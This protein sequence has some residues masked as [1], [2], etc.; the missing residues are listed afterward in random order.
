[1]NKEQKLPKETNK[2]QTARVAA[3]NR[4]TQDAIRKKQKGNEKRWWGGSHSAKRWKTLGKNITQR[5]RS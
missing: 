3:P 4:G 2:R 1:M 5:S